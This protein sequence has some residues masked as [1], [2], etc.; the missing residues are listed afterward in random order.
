MSLDGHI[1]ATIKLGDSGRFLPVPRATF[2]RSTS[3]S[4]AVLFICRQFSKVLPSVSIVKTFQVSLPQ[5]SFLKYKRLLSL[6]IDTAKKFQEVRA[7]D[8]GFLGGS[9]GKESAWHSGGPGSIPGFGRS[10]GKKNDNLLWCSCLENS[11]DRGAGRPQSMGCK[12]LD[13]NK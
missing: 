5:A 6:C 8:S 3:F 9:D 7:S 2:P 11:M 10:P 4:V 13:S 12:D 1:N